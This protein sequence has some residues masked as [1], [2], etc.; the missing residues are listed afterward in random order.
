MKRRSWLKEAITLLIVTFLAA[1]CDKFQISFPHVVR[2][3]IAA[4]ETSIALSSDGSRHMAWTE[5]DFASA[6]VV[7]AYEGPAGWK[8][9]EVIPPIRDSYEFPKV[10]VTDNGTVYITY[11][12][13]QHTPQ[14]FTT[15]WE[16]FSVTN[17]AI[18]CHPVEGNYFVQG[19]SVTPNFYL[20]PQLVSHADTVFLAYF[21]TAGDAKTHLYTKKL[22]PTLDAAVDTGFSV[23]LANS[24]E[25]MRKPAL[26]VDDSGGLSLAVVRRTDISGLMTYLNLFYHST[27]T[28]TWL[29]PSNLSDPSLEIAR[30]TGTLYFGS[31]IAN[32]QVVLGVFKSPYIM[33]EFH[34]EMLP[35]ATWSI[36]G[37]AALTWINNP[38]WPPTMTSLF[39][40]FSGSKNGAG[41]D[42]YT[43]QLGS[44][45]VC[46]EAIM[47]AITSDGNATVETDPVTAAI[48]QPEISVLA[49]T[50]RA[51]VNAGGYVYKDI[52]AYSLPGGLR[53]V[54]TS[55]N[56]NPNG[57]IGLAVNGAYA[58]GI[59][60]DRPESTG[61]YLPMVAYTTNLFFV[62]QIS[63]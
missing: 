55:A 35:P 62:P 5:P 58:A 9:A 15:C 8:S 32:S 42:I 60:I 1:G 46:T 38:S 49:V 45:S 37:P 41:T 2:N 24:A 23:N 11:L 53:K 51:L 18:D 12:W 27:F 19:G 6:R 40:T 52:Y 50:W 47:T 57:K 54:Y 22:S 39:I 28:F 26:A 56:T 36:P 14:T 44:A 48:L 30:S 3:S 21:A 31:V 7:Y 16:S 4:G 29:T 63:R 59:W 10:A 17:I 61:R 33:V 20:L 25:Y 13:W 43:C 34:S